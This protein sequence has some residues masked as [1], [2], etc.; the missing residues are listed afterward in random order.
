MGKKPKKEDEMSEEYRKKRDRNNQT[1]F[2]RGI[3][4]KRSRVKS[5]KRTEETMTRVN[6]LKTKNK[7]LETKIEHLNKELKFLKDL[8]MTQAAAKAD[9]IDVAQLKKLLAEN[10]DSEPEDED[11]A[12]TSA[13]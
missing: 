11:L 4:V 6:Q 7:Q 5:K 2:D 3:A 8:F 12:N 1:T 9:K 10:D 13:S